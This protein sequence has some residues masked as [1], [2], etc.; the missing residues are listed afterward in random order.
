MNAFLFPVCEEGREAG[1]TSGGQVN[2]CLHRPELL[3]EYLCTHT[4]TSLLITHN[5]ICKEKTPPNSL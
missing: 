4:Y 1:V 2:E 3:N 5:P